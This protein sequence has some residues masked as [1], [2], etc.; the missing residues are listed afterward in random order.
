MNDQSMKLGRRRVLQLGAGLAAL[1]TVPPFARASVAPVLTPVVTT[2]NGAVQGLV[3]HGIFSFK[4]VRYGAAPIGNL[5]FKPPQKPAPWQGALDAI[6]YGAPAMQ[7]YTRPP[8]ATELSR[9]LSTIFTTPAQVKIDNEDCLYLN[10]WS[11]GVGD[12]KKRAVMFWIHGGGYAYGSSSWPIYDGANL[13]RRGDVVVVSVNHRLNLFGY[14]YLVELG[15][16]E[17]ASS[18]NVGMLDLVASLEWV[19]DNIASFGGDPGNVTIFGESGGGSKVST[20]LAMPAAKGLFHKAIIES[21]PGLVGAP[22]AAATETA[23]TIMAELGIEPTNVAALTTVPAETLIAAAIAADKKQGGGPGAFVR[24]SPVV[25]GVVLPSD[26]FTPVAPAQSAGIPLLIGTN[27]D[28]MTLFN[29]SEPWF[30]TLDQAGLATRAKEMVGQ[31]AD[32]LIAAYHARSPEY[33]PAYLLSALNT[34]SFMWSGSIQLAERK[35]AQSALVYMYRLDWETPV[36]N[37]V[38]K[39]PHT[40]EIPLVFDNVEL[41]RVLVGDGEQPQKLADQ[42]S[43][44]WTAFAKTGV[45]TATDVPTWPRYESKRRAT[46]IFGTPTHVVDDPDGDIRRLYTSG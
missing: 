45:P 32:T 14:L 9:Q 24:L 42:M 6:G 23:R 26:P 16:A 20:L 39:A 12:G 7:M 37:G 41:A 40:L 43:S 25:D 5:R 38:F 1:A 36:A 10:V 33:T 13:A 19:R 18:G 8:P 17:Y 30:A 28:E 4:G 27:K 22:K 11:P 21:G 2:T 35:A 44:A 34:G 31:K 29:L 46:M 3:D 15:G